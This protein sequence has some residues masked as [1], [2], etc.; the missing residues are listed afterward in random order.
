METVIDVVLNSCN[1]AYR[2]ED[3]IVYQNMKRKYF[4]IFIKKI[5]KFKSD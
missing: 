5:L 4:V 1:I 2:D 3:K